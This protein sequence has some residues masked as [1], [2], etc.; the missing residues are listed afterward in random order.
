M[1]SGS[2]PELQ[3]G[4]GRCPAWAGQ[5]TVNCL[6]VRCYFVDEPLPIDEPVEPLPVLG[7]V[8]LGERVL[9][10]PLDPLE[11]PLLMPDELPVE[12]PLP[13]L[14]VPPEA[15]LELDLLKCASH[16]ARDTWPSLFVSTSEKLGCELD[17]LE[18]PLAADG[19][20]DD[21]EDG[22]L[23]EED[24]AGLLVDESLELLPLDDGDVADGVLDDDEGL[25]EDDDDDWATA[26]D[27]SANIT[28]AAVTPRVLG[29]KRSP[30]GLNKNYL[31]LPAI[32]VPHEQGPTHPAEPCVP[33]GPGPRSLTGFV[34]AAR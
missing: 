12:L 26:S 15:P 17:E 32:R 25:L 7:E 30:G 14:E 28:A 11:L 18:L 27:D 16:S 29:M 5:P 33:G 19:E 13:M 23:E 9:L 3:L 34:P 2:G 4:C 10:E 21:E 6:E 1:N 20:E 24:E 31:G 8:V 22:L